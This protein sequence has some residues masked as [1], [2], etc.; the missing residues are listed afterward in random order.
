[1]AI[2]NITDEVEENR[3][4]G[5]AL[6]ELFYQQCVG[7]YSGHMASI[8]NNPTIACIFAACKAD[9]R[10]EF[11]DQIRKFADA[12]DEAEVEAEKAAANLPF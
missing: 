9:G 2:K 7:T 5:A 10:H 8:P 4:T 11:A 1:M 12:I 3:R 6:A